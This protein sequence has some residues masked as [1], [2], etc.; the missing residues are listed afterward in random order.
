MN[1]RDIQELRIHVGYPA[2]TIIMPCDKKRIKEKF[3]E[4]VNNLDCE[5]QLVTSLLAQ[6]D[7]VYDQ[8]MCPSEKATVALFVN[9]YLARIYFLP[10]E[11]KE[12]ATT[13]HTFKLDLIIGALNRLQRYWVIDCTGGQ[14]KLL[15]GTE[16]FLT[17]VEQA[18]IGIDS[19]DNPV[20]YS[21][22]LKDYE[23]HCLEQDVLPICLLGD[24]KARSLYMVQSPYRER[25][26]AEVDNPVAIWPVMQ[27]Y[28]KQEQNA[29]LK[30]LQ[31]GVE[32]TS[33]VVRIQDILS[34]ARQGEVGELLVEQSYHFDACEEEVTRKVLTGNA[35]CPVGYQKIS[36]VDQIVE[37]VRSK[38]GKVIIVPDGSLLEF[39]RLVALLRF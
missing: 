2:I 19:P 4:I 30:K 23:R 33:Y 5:V 11:L 37:A 28:F 18:Y 13:G 25:I 24:S 6:F 32:G 34:A 7:V 27:G 12:V 3:A 29:L 38:G 26:F 14:A 8:L 10:F 20:K 31:D 35:T 17:D 16:D 39:R 9:K 36:L 1:R 22:H 21:S 15:E